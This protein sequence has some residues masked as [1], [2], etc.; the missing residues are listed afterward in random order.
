M[1]KLLLCMFVA[2]GTAAALLELRQQHL[3][4]E[5]QTNKLHNQIEGMQAKLWNQQ[6]GIAVDTSPNAL[7]AAVKQ[8]SLK[9]AAPQ[10]TGHRQSWVEDLD[11][12]Q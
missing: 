6:L 2:V 3:N 8:N 5:F 4:L 1:L 12:P 9:L 10:G 7:A 11:A